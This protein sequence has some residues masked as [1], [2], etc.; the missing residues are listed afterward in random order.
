VLAPPAT[1]RDPR[2]NGFRVDPLTGGPLEAQDEPLPGQHR[3]GGADERP[4]GRQVE[5]AISNQP[6]VSLSNDF[7][8]S[9]DE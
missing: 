9:A 5:D 2:H 1:V 3:I 6:E 4:G 7:A 8:R